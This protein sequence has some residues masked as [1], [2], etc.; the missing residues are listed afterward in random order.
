[1]V[2]T[3]P[4]S[5][6]AASSGPRRGRTSEAVAELKLDQEHAGEHDR[7][8]F[9]DGGEVVQTAAELEVRGELGR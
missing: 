3:A 9:F 1:V 7:G 8:G 5:R 4:S 2:Q 6:S